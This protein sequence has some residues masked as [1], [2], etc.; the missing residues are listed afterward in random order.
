LQRRQFGASPRIAEFG[1]D[2]AGGALQGVEAGLEAGETYF[3]GVEG[4]GEG[5][6]AL[7]D[8]ETVL[9]FEVIVAFLEVVGVEVGFG[10]AEAAD[11]PL[12][13]DEGIDEIALAW[14]NGVE[15]GV[16]FGGE[17]GEGFGVFAADDVGFGMEAGLESVQAG[18]GFAGLG[19]G[20]GR[21]LRIQAIRADLGFGWHKSS[22]RAGQLVRKPDAR[23]YGIARGVGGV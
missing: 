14:G 1:Q 2:G 10:E 4:V 16:V 20:A 3:E 22:P 12:V 6:L 21:F 15:L 19:A 13:V 17:L 7:Q 5:V 9:P 18:D 8:H 11:E 23:P